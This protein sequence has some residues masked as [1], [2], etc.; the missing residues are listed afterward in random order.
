M[1][2]AS[3][4]VDLR[5]AQV[6]RER[7][8]PRYSQSLVLALARERPSLEIACLIDPDREPPLFIDELASLCGIVEGT[9]SIPGL[10]RT[11]THFLQSGLLD[12]A[13]RVSNLFPA[14][15]AAHRPRLGAVLYDLI[16]W[17][18]PEAYLA[19]PR[20]A[21][22]YLRV[23]P[24]LS[25]L[26]RVF[27]ISESVRRDAIAI[28]NVEPSR[29]IT[30]HGGLDGTRWQARATDAGERGHPGEPLH[31]RNDRGEPFEIPTPYWLYVGGDDFRKNLPRLIEAVALL[32]GSGPLTA[33]VV[34][35]CSIEPA[36]RN[37]LL[38]RAKELGLR[39]GADIVF[40]GF[41]A[42]ETLGSLL[43]HCTATL[44]PSLYEGLGLP[45]LESYAFGKPV[46]ASDTS[47]FRELVPERC[48]FDP[49][50]AASI[51]DAMR[52]FW[53][54]PTISEESLAFAPTA[55]ALGHWPGAARHLAGWLDEEAGPQR[56]PAARPLW[57]ASSL[58]PDKSGVAVVT[59]RSLAAPNMPVVFFAPVRSARETEDARGSLARVRH[60]LQREPASAEILSLRTLPQA[61]HAAAG[62]PVLFVLGNSEHHLQ[63]LAHLF[64]YGAKQSDAVYL[65]DVH[66]SGAFRILARSDQYRGND[67]YDVPAEALRAQ[68]E[69]NGG[70]RRSQW[71]A[72][73]GSSC[74]GPP[75]HCQLRGGRGSPQAK[76]GRGC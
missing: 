19:D 63:T 73:V 66:L 52:R 38:K 75:F 49:Y 2:G 30:I 48:R 29:V 31:I 44:F 11:I 74:A 53:D 68:P 45:V 62:Q 50:S 67:S 61:R 6:N 51:A 64:T 3:L 28:A 37:D 70:R 76:L 69:R 26:D 71:A 15:L 41:V 35:A 32:K 54:D 13:K 5:V 57:V 21:S 36:R 9:A 65:H 8:I 24:A 14:E 42:D 46:I 10:D 59:Q 47:A 17:L 60:L 4:L 33:P 56:A 34:V 58:P 39:P 22:D 20:T 18:F 12:R 1:T 23:L 16:P 7:G 27:A 72:S 55:I 43:A 25:R 40:T